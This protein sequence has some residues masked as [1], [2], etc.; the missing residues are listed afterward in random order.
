MSKKKI[1]I[2]TGLFFLVLTSIRL[3]WIFTL[4]PASHPYAVQ[5]VIDLRGWNF[6]AGRTLTLSGQWEFYP[7]TLLRQ[8][9]AGSQSDTTSKSW[10]Q[11]PGDWRQ[12]FSPD[13]KSPLGYGSYRLHVLV[14]PRGNQEFSLQ[15]MGA[16]AS[17]EVFVNGSPLAHSGHPADRPEIYTPNNVPYIGTFTTSGDA[18][19]IVI[20]VANFGNQSSGGI[21]NAIKFGTGQALSREHRLSMGT[22]LVVC[23]VLLMHAVYA[24]I[25]YLIG[26]RQKALIYFALTLTCTSLALLAD[27]EK[28]LFAWVPVNY[29][30]SLKIPSLAYTGAGVF[31]LQFFRYLLPEGMKMTAFRPFF[32]LCILFALC[33]P[34]PTAPYTMITG[35]FFILIFLFPFIAVPFI[36]FKTALK[37][38]PDAIFLLLCATSL[39]VNALWGIVKNTVWFELGYYPVDMLISFLALGSFWSKQYFRAS[40]QTKLLAKKLQMADHVKDDFLANTSHEL[41]NPLH[42]MINIAQAVLESGKKTL[43]DKNVKNLELLITVGRRMSFMLNDLLDFTRLKD[44]RIHLQL[45]PVPLQ[46]VVSGVL[47][48]IRFMTE[49]K[50]I[51]LSNGIPDTFPD[52]KADENRL[53][54]IMFNLLHNAIKFTNEGRIVVG[55]RAINGTAHITI[56]DSGVGMDDETLQKIFMPY[57]QG[58]L[59]NTA[60]GGGFGLGLSICKQLVELH[61]GQLTASSKPGYGSVFTFTLP[62]ADSTVK[63]EE[64]MRVPPLFINQDKPSVSMY[65][66]LSAAASEVTA[67]ADRP[68]V[69]VVDDDPVNLSVLVN[70]LSPE[71]FD[72]VTASSGKEALALLDTKEW[73]LLVTDVMMPYMSGYELSRSIRS[74]FSMSELPI[75]LLTARSRP[76]DIDAGF[77]SGA[78][79]YVTKPVEARE[80][81]SRVRALTDLKRS[82]RERLRMEAAWLQAQIQPHFLFNT[83]N[84]VAALSEVD[85]ARMRTLL[86]VFGNY[87]H[88][89]FDFQNSARVVT[90]K[91]ELDLIRSYLYIE[92][93]RFG[94][95]LQIVWEVDED[96]ELQIPPL[97][98][99]PLVENAVKHGVLS[100]YRGGTIT[101]R[102]ADHYEYAEIAVIDDGVGMDQATLQ[103]LLDGRSDRKSGIG[104]LNTDRRLKQIYGKGLQ[105]RSIP[106]QG[107]TVTFVASKS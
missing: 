42:G 103:R 3:I 14:D 73:D 91:H 84:S 62:L 79:D 81:K 51:M 57:E 105:M 22:Q 97:S 2:V 80:L 100:R 78:N 33:T 86:D 49:N 39:T 65:P 61:G 102:I 74:R 82:V 72:L 54:Q 94:E 20:H 71:H 53:I 64:T 101:I 104:L 34:L 77:L 87:L 1:I 70:I 106:G 35:Y 56:S 36:I 92:K 75:L 17:S 15:M 13:N 27:D 28:M 66:D 60:I 89:S 12:A 48:M 9:A 99:Q 30:W 32:A 59:G 58:D 93:E 10:V 16:L 95:R 25:L 40:A 98:I 26:T 38:T 96:I 55:A 45:K 63:V 24:C 5:G 8:N 67:S 11:V 29:D 37:G 23:T 21:S 85:T 41:R 69:L 88:G 47:D 44:S 31:M 19:D 76:E 90:L 107:T 7:N 83:L 6:D 18:I 68:N 50:P 52:V 4:G 46:T 43:G